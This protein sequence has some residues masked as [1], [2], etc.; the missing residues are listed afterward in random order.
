MI[1][2]FIII[3][4]WMCAAVV[5]TLPLL[6]SPANIAIQILFIALVPVLFMLSFA[7]TLGLI[8]WR[9]QKGIIPGRFPRD[10]K[11]PIYF[12]RRIYGTCWTQIFYFKP[13][14]AAVLAIPAFKKMTL[15]LFGMKG[16]LNFTVYPDTWIRDLPLL[17]LG[18]GAYL[19]NRATIGTNVVLSDGSILV[20]GITIGDNALIG[21]LSIIGA[22]SKIGEKAEIGLRA[23]LGIR[24]KIEKGADVKPQCSINHA[25]VIGEGAS[26]GAMSFIGLRCV[27]GPGIKVPP[28]SNIPNGKILRSQSDCD[29]YFSMETADLEK[30]RLRILQNLQTTEKRE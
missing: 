19:A 25:A 3:S 10:T 12:C 30:H 9:F 20:D 26:V 21:H 24:V 1:T 13:L 6:L 23:T 7:S 2:S 29:K 5:S 17:N 8:S 14:Y 28:G 4:T 16:N 15:K 11:H 18:S 22:G 27:I